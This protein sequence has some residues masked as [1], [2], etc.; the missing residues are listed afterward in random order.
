MENN[1]NNLWIKNLFSIKSHLKNRALCFKSNFFLC[2]SSRCK[3]LNEL[4]YCGKN[5]HEELKKKKFN[6]SK[7]EKIIEEKNEK[8]NED[9]KNEFKFYLDQKKKNF[10]FLKMLIIKKL[11]KKKV[12][13]F[14][15]FLN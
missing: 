12:N 14:Y 10:L 7:I 6:E 13:F 9:R 15:F 2:N 4:P 1:I 3:T 5:Y 11:L 8:E